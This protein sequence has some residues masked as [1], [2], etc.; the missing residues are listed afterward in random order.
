MSERAK[1]SRSNFQ[2]MF[3]LRAV[4]YKEYGQLID[5]FSRESGLVTAVSGSSRRPKSSVKGCLQPFNLISGI[6]G[7]RGELQSISKVEIQTAYRLG[8]E[9]TICG[10][11]LNELL[12][13]LMEKHIPHQDIFDN[14]CHCLKY[15]CSYGASAVAPLLRVFE[16]NILS[17]TGYGVN[18]DVDCMGNRIAS[19]GRYVFDPNA[20]F[21]LA[22]EITGVSTYR[23][24]DLVRLA[25]GHFDDPAVLAAAKRVCRQAIDCRLGGRQLRSR[26]L[27]VKFRN[28]YKRA[29]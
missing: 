21:V 2:Q 25:E 22:D 23:G 5:L 18:F 14:Y 6:L 7:G 16:L 26:E 10:Q 1:I 9:E 4:P 15:L 20:G 12:F 13:Y 28:L 17:E 3:V 8:V 29:S 27:F 19:D 24:I 11:Y